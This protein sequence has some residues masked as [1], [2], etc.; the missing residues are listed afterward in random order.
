MFSLKKTSADR[1]A[2][3]ISFLQDVQRFGWFIE[4]PQ[5]LSPIDDMID[6]SID[7]LL[8]LRMAL[9]EGRRRVTLNEELL[10]LEEF[11]DDLGNPKQ[12]R[13]RRV[14]PTILPSDEMIDSF[15]II[16]HYLSELRRLEQHP[17][18]HE[19]GLLTSRSSASQQKKV[20]RKEPLVRSAD[21]EK[22]SKSRWFY[23]L[24]KK[25]T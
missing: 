23:H 18:F 4:E 8:L 17:A 10:F 14:I 13:T 21:A 1:V 24:R 20:R 25:T 7:I 12:I 11:Q 22:S 16:I 9:E 15:D 19:L 2:S 3:L 5:A 6:I